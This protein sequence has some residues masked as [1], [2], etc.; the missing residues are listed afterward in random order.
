[1]SV[2]PVVTE[3]A[4]AAAP[5]AGRLLTRI[6]RDTNGRIG[7]VLTAILVLAALCGAV[8]L[9]PHDPIAQFPDA[10]YRPPSADYWFGS[11][12]FGR[13]ILARVAAGIWT[14]LRVSVVSVALATLV[15]ATLGVCAGFF[16]GWLDQVISRFVE[17]LFAFPAILLALAVVSALGSGWFNTAVAIAVVY[18]PIFARVARGPT[19]SVRNAE[20]V[21]AQR[22]LG[23]PTHRIL[24]RHVLPNISAPVVV[25]VTLALSWAI[26]T[27]SALSF[28]GLGTQPPEPSLGLMVADAQNTITSAWWTMAF[29]AATIVVAVVA[30]NL[31]GDGLRSA[32]DPRREQSR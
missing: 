20:F 4:T 11:D 12:Q 29:P 5:P 22:V 27:E 17:V 28:L 23:I 8:G 7:L 14:S 31:L 18:T 25:Q 24:L 30:L 6:W 9:L 15:G 3:T 2:T 10:R 21:N 1:M 13:D 26:L 19:L 32:L 16:G